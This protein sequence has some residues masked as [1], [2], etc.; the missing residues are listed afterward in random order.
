MITSHCSSCGAVN[1]TFHHIF[2][3]SF[4]PV[5]IPSCCIQA[6]ELPKFHVSG[7]FKGVR[8]MAAVLTWVPLLGAFQLRMFKLRR[9][10]VLPTRTFRL[11]TAHAKPGT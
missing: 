3:F 2:A 1:H 11:S 5:S 10:T 4:K 8:V 9:Q 6:H 7:A